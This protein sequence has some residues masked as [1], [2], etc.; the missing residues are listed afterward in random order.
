VANYYFRQQFDEDPS[1]GQMELVAGPM[2]MEMW[3]NSPRGDGIGVVELVVEEMWRME[4]LALV[5]LHSSF[6]TNQTKWHNLLD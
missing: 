1:E 4:L 2:M 3:P 6:P 5:D